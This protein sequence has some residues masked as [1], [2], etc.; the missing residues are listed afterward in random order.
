MA[1]VSIE[2][3]IISGGDSPDLFEEALDTGDAGFKGLLSNPSTAAAGKSRP[4]N[5]TTAD[6]CIPAS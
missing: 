5:N 1:N 4:L 3:Y 2:S 6:S